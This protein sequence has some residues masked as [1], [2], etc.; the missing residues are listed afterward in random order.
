MPRAARPR[1]ISV[2]TVTAAIS[3]VAWGAVPTHEAASRA[4]Q[5]PPPRRRSERPVRHAPPPS[6][7]ATPRLRVTFIDVGQGDG[8][9]LES[10][11]GHAAMIDAGPPEAADHVRAVLDAHHVTALDWVMFSHPHLDHIGA[12]ASVL[13][14]V[15]VA[16]VVD[17]AYPHAIATYDR[18]LERI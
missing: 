6:E 9:L 13:D 12:G 4:A 5:S 17:P 18:L 10:G 8:A 15:R 11:D 14:H 2:I 3:C 1:S 16:R 7:P